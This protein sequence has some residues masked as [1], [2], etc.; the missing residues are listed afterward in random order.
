MHLKEFGDK[1]LFVIRGLVKLDE[2]FSSYND[3]IGKASNNWKDI[4][5]SNTDSLDI[6]LLG[7]LGYDY[8]NHF[9][10][11]GF[12]ILDNDPWS[13]RLVEFVFF[14]LKEGWEPIVFRSQ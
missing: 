8:V 4:Y 9:R 13:N 7:A 10:D 12:D 3:D 5:K 6:D 2:Q 11:V 14:I 1:N